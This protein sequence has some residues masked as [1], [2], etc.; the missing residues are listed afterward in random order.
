MQPGPLAAFMS[1]T[2]HNRAPQPSNGAAT[3]LNAQG[4]RY[5]HA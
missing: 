2:R 5:V 3:R 1:T 4:E